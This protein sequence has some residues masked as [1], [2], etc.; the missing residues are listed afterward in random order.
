[1]MLQTRSFDRGT[2]TAKDTAL[3]CLRYAAL[4]GIYFW[5]CCPD[6]FVGFLQL[7]EFQAKNFSLVSIKL[8]E[9]C[10]RCNEQP[11]KTVSQTFL[12]FY[13]NCSKCTA[14]WKKSFISIGN[15]HIFIKAVFQG[16]KKSGPAQGKQNLSM[17][18]DC[19]NWPVIKF[20]VWKLFLLL[21]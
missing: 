4:A 1:M 18:E 6:P 2:S 19:N 21:C 5:L 14:I 7:P 9:S 20:N 16:E 11:R 8:G 17:W 10:L 15:C 12:L 3:A 13:K